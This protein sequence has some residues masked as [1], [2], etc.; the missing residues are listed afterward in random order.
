[1]SHRLRSIRP[2][3]MTMASEPVYPLERLVR[4]FAPIPILRSGDNITV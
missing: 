4:P 3:A 1:M 2:E